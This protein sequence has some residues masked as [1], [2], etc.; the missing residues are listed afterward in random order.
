MGTIS[1]QNSY[2]LS[3][4][5][6]KVLACM[7][8][9]IDHTANI[10]AFSGLADLVCRQMIGRLAFP[11]FAFLLVEGFQHTRNFR[12][13]FSGI[14]L[15]AVLSEI[16]FDLTISENAGLLHAWQNQNTLFTLSLG[17]LMLRTIK[18]AEELLLERSSTHSMFNMYQ[19]LVML[20]FAAAAYF[21]HLD[22][23]FFGPLCIGAM[24]IF[25]FSPAMASFWG[26]TALNLN[27]LSMPGAFF[28]MIPISLYDGTRGKQLKYAFY[29]FYPLHLLLL[30]SLKHILMPG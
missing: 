14:F 30:F 22:Y 1:V 20:P 17:L 28:S 15:L 6:L 24:Y 12:K 3:G 11:I 26:C 16:F 23:G 21:L 19:A 10:F 5:D 7:S 2:R 29:L 18:K 13:Y 4:S 27:M 9:L 8:M 25:R